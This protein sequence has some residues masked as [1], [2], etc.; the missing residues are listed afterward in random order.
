MYALLVGA[1]NSVSLKFHGHPSVLLIIGAVAVFFWWALTRLGPRELA[2]GHIAS[3][4]IASSRNKKWL[5][6]GVLATF[7]FSYWPLHDIAEKYLFLAHMTQHTVFTLVSPVCFLL[8]SPDW[9][10]A[11]AL[12]NKALRNVVAFASKPIV[13]LMVFN[14]LIAITHWPSL[15]EYSLHNELFHFMVHA[16]LFLSATMMW[17]PVINRRPELPQLNIP[18]KM[19]YLFAQS[20]VPTV[21]ASFL[22]FS[23][24]AMYNTYQDAPRMI[25]GLDALGDQQ[26]AGAIMK[27][28]AGTYL[29][30]IVGYLF[31]R[32]WKNSKA[33]LSD[34]NLAVSPTLPSGRLN[35]AGMT[36]SGGRVAQTADSEVLTW[37]DVEQEFARLDKE[38]ATQTAATGELPSA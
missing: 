27:V 24:K 25:H 30:G 12:R 21:P 32:W 6:A 29:W 19:M 8:G 36:V 26:L 16:V 5:S 9:L 20:I 22:T 7:V 37:H 38:Q 35:I 13:A 18:V 33:G 31:F 3:G 10:W 23:K 11:W 14:A 34:G 15:V 17:I 1:E 2:A 4:E 28:G